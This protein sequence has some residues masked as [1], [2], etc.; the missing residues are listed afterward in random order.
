VTDRGWKRRI[1]DPMPLPDGRR[2]VTLEDAG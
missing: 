1:D 2:L